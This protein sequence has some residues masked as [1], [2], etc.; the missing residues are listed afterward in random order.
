MDEKSK[1]KKV[2]AA[3]KSIIK[4]IEETFDEP[5][6]KAIRA[7]LR[8]S[9]GKPA[10]VNID[11]LGMVFPSIPYD[12]LGNG[13]LTYEEDAILTSLQLYALHKQGTNES[14]MP[15]DGNIT[16]LG[17]S[18]GMMRRGEE[19][20]AIDRRFNAMITAE[21]FDELKIH[22]RHLIKLLKS[23]EETAKVDYP[24]LAEN[25]FWIENGYNENVKLRW[26]RDYYR[27]NIKGE[28]KDEK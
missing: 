18:L 12:F 15:E 11:V 26:A 6:Q 14:V 22:L 13:A 7:K 17:A 9:I 8:N 20:K 1:G 3:T 24:L 21:S 25:L 4:M 16:G 2:Y 10:L 23:K 5:E 28:G 19:T 27:I